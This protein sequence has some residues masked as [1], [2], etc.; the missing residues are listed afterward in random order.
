MALAQV[1]TVQLATVRA[2]LSQ[3]SV[4]IAGGGPVGASVAMLVADVA[5][6]TLLK[7]VLADQGVKTPP[8]ADVHDLTDLLA[9]TKPALA[10]RPELQVARRFRAARNPVQHAGFVPNEATV[11]AHVRDAED[12]AGLV[13]Q[14]VYGV[15][16]VQVS[17]AALIR[18]P[19]LRG[20]LE[21]AG[22]FLEEGKVDHACVQVAAAFGLLFSRC[23]SWIRP[24]MGVTE[25]EEKFGGS[26][27]H[28]AVI[29]VFPSHAEGYTP[30]T[31]HETWREITL[32]SLGLPLP[33]LLALKAIE[34]R[35]DAV[36]HAS[37]AGGEPE[38]EQPGLAVV[39]RAL[40][41]LT[42]RVWRLE[43]ADPAIVAGIRQT[44]S[45]GESGRPS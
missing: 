13:V 43:S 16:L 35:A 8:R 37:I 36:L 25:V 7:Q 2:L 26:D 39:R 41:V 31:E 1:T 23:G 21:D 24:I 19:D 6:E 34:A 27:F 10:N 28:P 4:A 12:F 33:D 38:V 17:L 20:A 30:N 3:A 11:A 22:G 5:L 14:E 32:V 42:Q 29:T 40:D 18:D 9:Q 45:K 15:F 44:G